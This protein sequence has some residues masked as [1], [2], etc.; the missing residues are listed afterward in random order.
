MQN[1]ES[2]NVSFSPRWPAQPVFPQLSLERGPRDAEDLTSPALVTLGHG[3][4]AFDMRLFQL[5][6][7]W[8]PV[9]CGR[10]RSRPG[11]LDRN[12]AVQDEVLFEQE[13]SLGEHGG[14]R[15]EVF[16][17]AHVSRP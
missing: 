6:K 16:Q 11:R 12:L 9:G 1:V 17:L 8:H 10:S 13:I 15:E 7:G 5:V 3:E 2:L 4:D 14:A